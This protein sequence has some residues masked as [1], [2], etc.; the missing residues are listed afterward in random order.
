MTATNTLTITIGDQK[1]NSHQVGEK[2]MFVHSRKEFIDSRVMGKSRLEV[3]GDFLCMT[4]SVR[5]GSVTILGIVDGGPAKTGDVHFSTPTLVDAG[6]VFSLATSAPLATSA[7]CGCRPQDRLH[8]E[9]EKR[10]G[11]GGDSARPMG[12]GGVMRVRGCRCPLQFEGPDCQQTAI[13]FLGGGYAWFPPMKP[14]FDS[15]LSVEFM[16]EQ[17]N[18]LL[19]YAGPLAPLLPGEPQDYMAIGSHQNLTS[20]GYPQ[21]RSKHLTGCIGNLAVDSRLYDLGSPAES[22]N[23]MTNG[24]S[25]GAGPFPPHGADPPL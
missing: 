12:C 2:D 14:C 10:G 9:G 13:S 21:L 25:V 24:C 23:S 20:Y 5:A 17:E 8:L 22:F 1:D 15:H 4:L 11:E 7:A 18:G 19:L 16:T 6:G 3:F